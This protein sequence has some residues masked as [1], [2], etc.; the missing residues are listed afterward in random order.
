LDRVTGGED[1]FP[2]RRIQ[3]A[4]A[5][6]WGRVAEP[7]FAEGE[8]PEGQGRSEAAPMRPRHFWPPSTVVVTFSGRPPAQAGVAPLVVVE[9]EVRVEPP[10]ERARDRR[11]GQTLPRLE[12]CVQYKYG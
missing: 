4:W 8:L 9:V 1:T 12:R 5:A 11:H 10:V 7:V 6:H 2:A 3:G